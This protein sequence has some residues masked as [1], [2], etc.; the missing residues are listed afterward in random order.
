[1]KR[2]YQ[3]QF[4]NPPLSV[5]YEYSTRYALTHPIQVIKSVLKVRS[6]KQKDLGY[7]YSTKDVQ[8]GLLYKAKYKKAVKK[9]LYG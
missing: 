7:A 5:G 2:K 8:G 6:L 9:I 3:T 1:M 4:T